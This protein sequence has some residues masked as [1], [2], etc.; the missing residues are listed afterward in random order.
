VTRLIPLRGLTQLSTLTCSADGKSFF[1][2]TFDVAG[3]AV[4][5]VTREGSYHLLYKAAKE[6]EGARPSIDGRY[7]AF[8]DV[9]SASNV[10]VVEGFPK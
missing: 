7:L 2:T 5:H 9:Q 8:G 1:A 3:S 6:V 10:W 4:Y